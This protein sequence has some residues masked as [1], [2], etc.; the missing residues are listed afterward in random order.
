MPTTAV[1]AAISARSSACASISSR[2]CRSVTWEA[3]LVPAR[4]PAARGTRMGPRRAR[5]KSNPS[6][7]VWPGEVSYG[8]EVHALSIRRQRCQ[9]M[10][11]NWHAPGALARAAHGAGRFLGPFLGA[12]AALACARLALAGI[13]VLEPAQFLRPFCALR[14]S[15]PLPDARPTI[16]QI[17]PNL[18]RAAPRSPPWR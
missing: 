17:V 10:A 5:K 1:P 14:R 18:T 15:L 4:T 11:T 16:A 2:A 12:G 9:G 3:G 13:R 6:A 7:R 8:I